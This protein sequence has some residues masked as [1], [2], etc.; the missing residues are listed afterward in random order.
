MPQLRRAS[1]LSGKGVAPSGYLLS[2]VFAGVRAAP[3]SSDE[4]AVR[5]TEIDLCS[6]V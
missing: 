1:S 4:R 6:R 2:E 5:G 3:E